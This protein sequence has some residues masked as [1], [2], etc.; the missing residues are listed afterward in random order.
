MLLDYSFLVT[1]LKECLDKQPR[2]GYM[3]LDGLDDGTTFVNAISDIEKPISQN[4]CLL[5]LLFFPQYDSLHLCAFLC[6]SN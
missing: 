3:G 1:V 2:S 6:R 4:E 5:S